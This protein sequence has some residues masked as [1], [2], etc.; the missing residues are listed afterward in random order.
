MSSP[1]KV[2]FALYNFY[3]LLRALQILITVLEMQALRKA[4]ENLRVLTFQSHNCFTVLLFYFE[5]S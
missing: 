3:S 4:A 5:K 1:H 2:F